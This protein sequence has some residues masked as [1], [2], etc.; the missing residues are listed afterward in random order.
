MTKQYESI[1]LD[2]R[3]VD[4]LR[5]LKHP[6]QSINGVIIEVLGKYNKKMIEELQREEK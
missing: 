6:G 2:K 5:K 3:L 4:L 1:K